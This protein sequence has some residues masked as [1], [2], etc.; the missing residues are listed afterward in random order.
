MYTAQFIQKDDGKLDGVLCKNCDLCGCGKINESAGRKGYQF[1]ISPS[2]GFTRR[3]V[4]RKHL[5]GIIGV[6]CDGIKEGAGF[7]SSNGNY[8]ERC[9]TCTNR[10][11]VVY[12]TLIGDP[13][14]IQTNLEY[15]DDI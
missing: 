4:Q 12:D 15:S 5:K 11:P 3:L 10:E 9:I 7:G 8:Q 13:A 14:D 6:A 2:V 1:Y